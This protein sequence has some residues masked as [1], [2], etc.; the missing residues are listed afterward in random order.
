MEEPM[1]ALAVLTALIALMS[2][3][4]LAQAPEKSDVKIV[5][6]FA[7]QGSRR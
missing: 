7:F 2:G 3:P 5:L 6:D 4:V 1:K